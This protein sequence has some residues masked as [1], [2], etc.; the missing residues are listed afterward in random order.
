MAQKAAVEY[1]CT[2]LMW[3]KHKHVIKAIDISVTHCG[4]L[5]RIQVFWDV[6]LGPS[7][8]SSRCLN[9]SIFLQNDVNQS[10]NETAPR[11][12]RVKASDNH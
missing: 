10:P 8:T 1:F 4:V 6:T 12:K 3:K 5:K 11:P 9:G 7:V 2:S